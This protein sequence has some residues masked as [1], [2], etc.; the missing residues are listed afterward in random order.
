MRHPDICIAGAGIIGLSLALDLHRRGARVTV[1]EQSIPLSEASTAAA[2]ML[3]ALDPDNP[4]QLRPL[5]DLSLSLYPAFIDRL[6]T[7]SAIHVPFHTHTTLQSLPPHQ[8]TLTDILTPQ[9]LTH[10]LPDLHLGNHRFV[11]LDEHSLDPRELAAALLAAIHATAIDLR[12]H[13]RVLSA[14]SIGDAVEVHTTTGILHASQFVDCTGAWAN[15][16]SPLPHLRVTPKK[17]QMLAV[18]LPPS[19]PLHFVL[20][21]P[22]IYIVPRTSTPTSTRAIIGATIED[23]GFDKTV[24]PADIAR[25][26]A[27]AAE[28][29]PALADAPQLEAWAGLRPA[30]PDGLPLLGPLLGRPHQFLAAGHYRNGILL[31]PATA[32]VMAQLLTGE[33]PSLDLS[34]FAPDRADLQL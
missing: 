22:E 17:G 5:A 14:I 6:H 8:A 13:T 20:R 2:G 12:P 16:S 21:T 11:L 26:R 23:A 32:H 10:L 24:H 29:L 27:R 31:A 34:P 1:L 30:T 25:L 28:L 3:A 18:S 19:L 4:P 15:A 7:L 9:E 33:T